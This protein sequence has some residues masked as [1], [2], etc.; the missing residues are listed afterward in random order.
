MSLDNDGKETSNYF[1]MRYRRI[2]DILS[3][4]CTRQLAKI[5]LDK[6]ANPQ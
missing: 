2:L 6:T 3:P 4:T 1:V 5:L